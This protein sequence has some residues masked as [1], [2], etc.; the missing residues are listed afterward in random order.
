M[1]QRFGFA[2]AISLVL[3]V[4]TTMPSQAGILIVTGGIIGNP[5]LI[6]A[7]LL[8]LAASRFVFN[9]KK[10]TLLSMLTQPT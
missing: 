9:S 5:T 7:G 8:S 4:A 10:S 6:G 3:S 2:L 1:T